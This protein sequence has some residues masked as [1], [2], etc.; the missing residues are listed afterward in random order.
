M[1][2]DNWTLQY[3]NGQPGHYVGPVIRLRMGEFSFSLPIDNS[4]ETCHISDTLSEDRGYQSR[5]QPTP[6][7]CGDSGETLCR[8]LM[9]LYICPYKK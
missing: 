9:P 2:R 5:D 1:T 8:T 7:P 4:H 6:P 3:W